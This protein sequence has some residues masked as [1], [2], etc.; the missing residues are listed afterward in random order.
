[1]KRTDEARKRIAELE[2][3]LE[4]AKRQMQV[5]LKRSTVSYEVNFYSPALRE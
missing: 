1:M 5:G 3:D 4:E 2:D